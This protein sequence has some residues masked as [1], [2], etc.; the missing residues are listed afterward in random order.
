MYGFISRQYIA[1]V[2]ALVRP[3]AL[4]AR[5]RQAP[6]LEDEWVRRLLDE[7]G[8]TH[9]YIGARGGSIT[10]GILLDNPYWRLVYSNGAAWI[11]ERGTDE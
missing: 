5:P 1:E 3:I 2:N 9:L 6:L 11:F 10:P 8:V 4:P 7:R